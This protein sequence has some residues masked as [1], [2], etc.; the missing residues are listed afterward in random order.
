MKSYTCVWVEAGI[1]FKRWIYHK[2]LPITYLYF[3]FFPSLWSQLCQHIEHSLTV[4]DFLYFDLWNIQQIYFRHFGKV[5]K[6]GNGSS[7]NH[8]YQKADFYFL[9][10]RLNGKS[11][12]Y[13]LINY[14]HDKLS[15]LSLN[16]NSYQL[17]CKFLKVTKE[18]SLSLFGK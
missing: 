5:V 18:D 10:L 12:Q 4:L 7:S 2:S 15:Q 9:F 1:I 16:S 8:F 6:Q 3:L 13:F 11:L 14:V 17:L